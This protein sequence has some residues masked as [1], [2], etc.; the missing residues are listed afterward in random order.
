MHRQLAN[1]TGKYMY[2]ATNIKMKASHI[3]INALC[4][5]TL[6]LITMNRAG[7]DG[8]STMTDSANTIM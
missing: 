1:W 3:G 4:Y 8:K 5:L 7:Y 6:R 2:L